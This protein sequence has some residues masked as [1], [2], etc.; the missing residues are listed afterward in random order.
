MTRISCVSTALC[1]A[2][3]VMGSVVASSTHGR[4][5]S[6][7]RSDG[8]RGE[9]TERHLLP[10]RHS[11]RCGRPIG[12]CRHVERSNRGSRELER[13]LR[14][15]SRRSLGGLVSLDVVLRRD[16]HRRGRR[17]LDVTHGRAIRLECFP[18]RRYECAHRDFVPN[19][20]T[21][22]GNRS[23]RECGHVD[24][25]FW[26]LGGM[27]RGQCGRSKPAFRCGVPI[28]KSLRGCRRRRSSR[29]ID[30]PDGRVGDWTASSVDPG[31]YLV[32]V[33][34]PSTTFCVAAD[35]AGSVVTSTNPS[36]GPDVWVLATVSN[37]SAFG[38]TGLESVS[39]SSDSLC[40]A[41]DDNGD[42]VTSTDPNGGTNAWSSANV[43][44]TS[45]FEGNGIT[46]VSCSPA[47]LCVAVDQYGHVIVGSNL[48][49][50]QAFPLQSGR[51]QGGHP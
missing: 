39:C 22:R 1:V 27:A 37:S 9:R 3:D 4:C 12:R 5:C 17:H 2:T 21:V 46:G 41:T 20:C 32:S 18:S 48:P 23:G 14:R 10:A 49:A 16:R 25:S 13:C 6:L 7:A 43:D 29:H 44:G 19:L 8:G 33:S 28:G 15:R 45:G 47:S 40:V 34:C 38:F 35:D 11:V 36:G 30:Q 26:R 42:V 24:R 50:E 51:S 31:N